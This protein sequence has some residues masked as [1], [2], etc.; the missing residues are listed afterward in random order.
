MLHAGQPQQCSNCLGNAET[1][2]PGL[3]KGR[4]CESNG[5]VRMFMSSYMKKMKEEL[6]IYRI[7]IRLNNMIS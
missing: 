2:C 5:G 4:N 3:G 7:I 6:M 1:G